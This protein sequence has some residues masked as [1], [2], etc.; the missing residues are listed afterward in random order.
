MKT[1]LYDAPFEKTVDSIFDS[2][3]ETAKEAYG[4]E[5]VAQSLD[6]AKKLVERV[7]GD[8]QQVVDSL[9]VSVKAKNPPHRLSVGKDAPFWIGLS[10]LPSGLGDLILA[11]LA[12]APKPAAAK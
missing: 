2:Y 1:P 3:S 7:N 11:T 8:P 10:F 12:K 4:R 6:A 5:F 9:C